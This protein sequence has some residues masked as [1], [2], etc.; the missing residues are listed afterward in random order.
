VPRRRYVDDFVDNKVTAV[1]QVAEQYG[2]GTVT[3]LDECGVD[4]PVLGGLQD[5]TC[6]C[7]CVCV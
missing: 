2:H 7:A 5:P 1:R 4:G 6:V 3:M